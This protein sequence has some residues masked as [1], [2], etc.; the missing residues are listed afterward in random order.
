[1]PKIDFY[2]MNSPVESESQAHETALDMTKNTFSNT[3]DNSCKGDGK[4]FKVTKPQKT[5]GYVDWKNSTIYQQIKTNSLTNY[6]S[7]DNV[8]TYK[9]SDIEYIVDMMKRQ[10]EDVVNAKIISPIYK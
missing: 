6:D 5:P 8:K 7:Q 2:D 1:M 3:E 10:K 4:F 9:E